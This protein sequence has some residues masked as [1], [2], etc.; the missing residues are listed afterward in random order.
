M[1]LTPLA[2]RLSE[3]IRAHGPVPFSSF[4]GAALYDAEFGYYSAAAGRTGKAGDFFTSVSVGPVFGELM[5]GQFCQVWEM[6]GRPAEFTVME[7]GANDGGFA[8]DVLNWAQK[9][10][11]DFYQ[12]LRYQIDEMLP[13][14]MERQRIALA[15]HGE[16]VTHDLISAAPCGCYFANEVLDA[17]PFRRVRFSGGEWRELMVG[18]AENGD[19][20]WVE[21]EPED[22][23]L[24]RRL[25]WLGQDFAEGYTTEIAPAVASQIRYAASRLEKGV[26]F[27]ADYGYSAADYYSESRTAGTLRCYRRHQAHE[28]PFNDVGETDITAHVD[29]SLAATAAVAAGCGVAGFLD[30]SRFLTGAAETVLRSMDGNVSPEAALWHRQFR[31]L[32]HP[33]HLGQNFHFLV[34][35]KGMPDMAPLSG[36][37]FARSSNAEELLLPAFAP[38]H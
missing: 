36:L 35:E 18:L 5:A 15:A 28:N 32:T 27:F 20:H 14:V 8:A 17:M 11:P 16:K 23:A 13:S 29:F 31:T 33:A 34:L 9:H 7:A 12:A 3:N 37:K 4:M 10:R 21:Q 26:L 6:T 22:R 2:L 19:F 25:A 30:Q 38:R 1:S 24:K